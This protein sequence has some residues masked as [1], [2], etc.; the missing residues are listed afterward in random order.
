VKQRQIAKTNELLL[1][2]SQ[3][4]KQFRA[5][6]L[7]LGLKHSM[8]KVFIDTM[9]RLARPY[10]VEHPGFYAV[11]RRQFPQIVRLCKIPEYLD[12]Q[13]MRRCTMRA[14]EIETWN[15]VKANYGFEHDLTIYER[16]NP[17]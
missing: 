15:R 8:P 3:D 6:Q 16:R 11:L 12:R 10:L 5:R 4:P 7:L 14:A 13:L 9:A 17:V 2:R 1:L